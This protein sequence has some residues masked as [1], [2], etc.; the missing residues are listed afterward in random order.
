MSLE[1]VVEYILI[2]AGN[3]IGFASKS[4]SY[5]DK[6]NRIWVQAVVFG[7]ERFHTYVYG[8]RFRFESDHEPLEVNIL[9]N[10]AVVPHR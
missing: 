10:L 8:T 4:H 1:E 2:Q 6:R 5:C 7:C 3:A 9:N